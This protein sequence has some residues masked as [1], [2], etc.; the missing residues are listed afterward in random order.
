MNKKSLAAATIVLGM[1]VT[2]CASS[3]SDTAPAAST[4]PVV[5]DAAT[6]PAADSTAGA[7]DADAHNAAATAAI[8]TAEAQLDG[9]VVD[10]EWDDAL[11]TDDAHW[12][13]DVLVGDQLHELQVSGDGTAVT[14]TDDDPD[15]ID[16]GD[17]ASYEAASVTITQAI[18]TAL[19]ER[20]GTV[21][22]VEFDESDV[23]WEVEID[24]DGL[25]DDDIVVDAR[26]G[27][28]VP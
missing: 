7:T 12:E 9:R 16:A 1:A 18:E 10:L 27:Q 5:T 25:T 24:G 28:I 23:E 19:A 6:T 21:T 20:P 13:L 17:V 11:A 14:R 26:T 3:T 15:T 8:E 4:Q 2:G 22:D